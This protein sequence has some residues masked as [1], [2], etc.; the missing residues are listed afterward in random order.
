MDKILLRHCYYYSFTPDRK[1]FVGFS[2]TATV[3]AGLSMAAAT[4]AA[5]YGA[6]KG[7][8]AM[9][10]GGR[11]SSASAIPSLPAAS[12]APTVGA[13]TEAEKARIRK[14][15][16]TILTTPLQG[17]EYAGGPTLLGSGDSTKKILLGG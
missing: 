9:G 1:R 15:T 10:G 5:G 14:K 12:P 4:G 13:A 11:T 6:Y 7:L 17:N 8:E 2:T 3:L 16:K